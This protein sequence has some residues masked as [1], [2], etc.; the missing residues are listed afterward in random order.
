MLSW[1][2]CLP[3]LQAGAAHLSVPLA[4]LAKAP[5]AKICGIWAPQT[6]PCRT[7]GAVEGWTGKQWKSP[8]RTCSSPCSCRKQ[9]VETLAGLRDLHPY[10]PAPAH[11]PLAVVMTRVRAG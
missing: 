7:W 5:E 6:C 4:G 11:H 3:C 10:S 2:Q 1:A 8:P 9:Q